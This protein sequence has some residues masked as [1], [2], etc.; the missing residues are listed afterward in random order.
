LKLAEAGDDFRDLM[1]VQDNVIRWN[2]VYRMIKRALQTRPSIEKFIENSIY[3]PSKHKIVPIED[4][5][6]DED[7]IILKEIFHI[8]KLFHDQTKRFQSRMEDGTHGAVWEAY[9]SCEYFLRHILDKRQQ[10][11]DAEEV[12]ETAVDDFYISESR[13]YIRTSIENCWAKLDE[14]Y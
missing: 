3:E 4:R 10:Y 14:Y 12:P 11:A 9:P 1:L 5:L 13:K 2:S 7:W 8:F 6:T